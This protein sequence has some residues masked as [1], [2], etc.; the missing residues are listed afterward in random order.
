MAKEIAHLKV[1]SEKVKSPAAKNIN[2]FG[3][4]KIQIPQ[5]A[6]NVH[7]FIKWQNQVE[8]YITETATISTER[9]AV[10]LLDRLT[11]KEIDVLRCQTLKDAW[12][13]L[14]GKYGYTVFIACLLLK[15]FHE[16]KL[17][18]ANDEANLIQ[19]KNALDKLH[20]DMKTN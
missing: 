6:G 4:T 5:F 11:P 3:Y 10:H 2:Y 13:K 20:S 17:T 19:L 8:D 12:D 1:E 15:D 16:L 7:E 18:K 14:I 9:Q